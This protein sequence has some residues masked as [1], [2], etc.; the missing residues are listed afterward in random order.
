LLPWVLGPGAR[1]VFGFLVFHQLADA[2]PTVSSD[3]RC[4]HRQNAGHISPKSP[5][6]EVSI[7][8]GEHVLFGPWWS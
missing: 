7:F 2:R 3:R 6:V 4:A 5:A 8:F 1:F